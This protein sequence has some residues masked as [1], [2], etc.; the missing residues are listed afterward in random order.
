M[1]VRIGLA[2]VMVS[3]WLACTGD[4][5]GRAPQAGGAGSELQAPVTLPGDFQLT[6]W[7]DADRIQVD[8]KCTALSRPNDPDGQCISIAATPGANAWGAVYWQTRRETG[9]R[10][11]VTLRQATKV[12]F[13]ARGE[14]GGEKVRFHLG[15]VAASEL[16]QPAELTELSTT[17]TRFELELKDRKL[18]QITGL[19]GVRWS[20]TS[21]QNPDGLKF[22]LDDIR[23][24]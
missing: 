14:Q 9:V 3:G 23:Y 11:P 8:D 12:T 18:E 17:W 24:E 7:G 22:Y 4:G 13:W 19:F 2:A 1:S 16:L 20:H 10:Q 15:G 21:G 6:L 5:G